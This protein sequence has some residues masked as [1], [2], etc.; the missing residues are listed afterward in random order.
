MPRAP[1]RL[2]GYA[3]I[4]DYA[5]IGDQ[6]TAA[7]VALDGSIDWLCLPRFDSPSAFA[8]I[9]DAR[10]GGA[11][12]LA[13]T[14]PFTAE[15][16]YLPRTNVLETTFTT[17]EGRV[18][19]T[20]A[21]TAGWRAPAWVE[22]LR[23]VE[24]LD[25]GVPMR[26][27][28]SP[29]F[30]WGATGG[31]VNERQGTPII[32]HHG[33]GLAVQAWDAGT[34]ECRDGTVAA[35]FEATQASRALLAIG[36]F[37]DE[38]LLLS[39]R[40]EVESRLDE[41]VGF[42]RQWVGRCS[43]DGPWRDAV[44]RS[45]LALAL[46][47]HAA[48]G[49]IVAAPTSSLPEAVGG[50]RNFDYRY[51]WLRDTSFALDAL[52]RLGLREEVHASLGWMLAA[53]RTTHPRLDVFYSLDGTAGDPQGEL[54][55]EGYR[56]SSPVHRGNSAGSQLQL[57]NY[58][59]LLDTCF[60]YV[61]DGNAL[62]PESGQR[63][64]EVADL[65]CEIWRNRD[66][67]IWELHDREDYAQ[68]K[69]ACWV[70]LDR[71]V[72][73]ADA[74]QVPDGS[75]G[76]W[77]ATAATVREFIDGRCW[78][79]RLRSYVRYPGTEDLDASM[80]LAARTGYLDG[81]DPRLGQTVDAMRRELGEGPFLY[82]YSGMREQEGAFLA[83]SFW[84]VE[85]LA[86]AGRLDEA[87]EAMDELVSAANDVGLLSEEIDPQSRELLGNFPQALSHLALVN[88]AF[89]LGECRADS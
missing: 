30:E 80:L 3:P 72:A 56:R 85:A 78:S 8:A 68:G 82:R 15:R 66:A 28:V 74:G 35:S 20:D 34:P 50:S 1:E 57:G 32:R 12:A 41:T 59:D 83:C 39:R 25:G 9:L 5:A 86:R 42:W 7:L 53:T 27:S 75:A 60:A 58:G 18:R 6:R 69:L 76:R 22:L 49:A 89:V 71:T 11:I 36:A 52:L 65:V 64:A 33:L 67:S 43:Y 37:E 62:D 47:S 23:R 88:A 73:L 31:E 26:W 19:V 44:L 61:R 48:S 77:K 40:E 54:D 79:S 63:L 45:A 70:A 81:N 2:D 46:C 87:T 16:R 24:G 13:P 10:S 14:V 17:T 29:R 21:M 38:P 4:R 84:M 55:L 51:N